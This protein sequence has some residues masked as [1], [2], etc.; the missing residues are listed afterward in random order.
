MAW[1]DRQYSDGAGAGTG[2]GGGFGSRLTGKSA[3]TWL[4]A[5]NAVIHIVD[6]IFAT[7]TRVGQTPYFALWGNFNVAQAIE[8]GQVW[9]LFTYQF[10]H[11]DFFH[12]LFNMI[13]LYFFGPL[14]ER[15]W[16]TRRFIVFYLLCGACGALLMLVL[17]YAGVIA[18]GAALIGASGSLYGILIGAAVL[19]P[20]MRVM[21]LIP[22]IPM[23]LRTMALVFLGI[24]FFSALA[25]S[26]DGGNAAHLGGAAL[27]FL[28]VKKPG[29][30]NFA[31]RL[32]PQAIQAGYNKGRFE[33]KMKNEQ[34]SQAEIDRILA[35]V[36]E[37]GL[38]TLT[39][40]E[41]KAL[42]QDTDR[43][44]KG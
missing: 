36:S 37:Q 32:N 23:S 13:G 20:K 43:L 11:L 38:H 19:Y 33:R 6:V 4:I 26:N 17:V 16:G 24:S 30:L 12:L 39:R 29:L 1:Q 2:G 10:L 41:K 18:K 27:G 42:K 44:R 31:D 9:R 3:V 25:G 14:L 22:P 21:L 40:R 28:L 8:G 5:L 34:A 15:W 7:G 35:K